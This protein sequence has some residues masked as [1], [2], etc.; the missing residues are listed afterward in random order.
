ME[1][2][3]TARQGDDCGDGGPQSQSSWGCRNFLVMSDAG[4]PI[5]V[6]HGKEEEVSRICSLLQAIRSSVLSNNCGDIKS[7]RSG[8]LCLVF[9][10]V[11]SITLVAIGDHTDTE[12]YLKLQLEYV[13][14]QIMFT[15]TSRVEKYFAY[16]PSFDLRTLLGNTDTIINGILDE[17]SP[18]GCPGRH[19]LGSVETAFPISPAIRARASSVLQAV[20]LKTDFTAFSILAVGD[21]LV[22]IVQPA[23]PAHQ[24]RTSDL[25]L[26]L[27]VIS[28]QLALQV[29]SELWIPVCLPRFSSQDF[30]F[31]YTQCLDAASKLCLIMVSQQSTTIQFQ[32]FQQA[33]ATIRR[34][35]DL[36]TTSES[37][38]EI[39]TK[40][41]ESN[42]YTDTNGNAS[43][44]SR[45]C[46]ESPQSST[47]TSLRD[48]K[49]RRNRGANGHDQDYVD[50]SGDGDSFIPYLPSSPS[51]ASRDDCGFFL[52][53]IQ[54]SCRPETAKSALDNYL[55]IGSA[56]HFAFRLDVPL[57][58]AVRKGHSGKFSQCI[59]APLGFPFVEDSSKQRVWNTYVKLRMRLCVGSST[60]ESTMGAFDTFGGRAKN[61]ETA[62][63]LQM[64]RFC[65]ALLLSKSSPDILDGISYVV[66]GTELYLALNGPDYEL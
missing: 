59:S 49:W 60:V 9:M 50:A 8:S 41:T 57:Q 28:R 3:A 4:K 27:Y 66:D 2:S 12:A 36:P 31:C 48:V 53:E 46:V 21:K 24:M 29:S 7:L 65:P 62:S 56:L 64:D 10:S 16:N 35:L 25:H 23:F 47:S 1:V 55:S 43:D 33:A 39:I 40:K 18:S 5:Y 52:R 17:S 30:L 11:G 6:R 32:I 22:T 38:L 15:V 14:C 26:L 34:S 20:G 54:A 19:I 45:V 51:S 63:D 58:A 44:D 13:F 37:V 61:N 42:G